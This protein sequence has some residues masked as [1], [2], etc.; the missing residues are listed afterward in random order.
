[1]SEHDSQ[2]Y[3]MDRIK[4]KSEHDFNDYRMDR[5]KKRSWDL[6]YSIPVIQ[7]SRNRVGT[8]WKVRMG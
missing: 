2:D 6:L 1:M 8:M 4:A 5:I 3:R 7:K